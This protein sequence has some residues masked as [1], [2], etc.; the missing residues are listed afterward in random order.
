MRSTAT[1]S[2]VLALGPLGALA[3]A[4]PAA[5]AVSCAGERATVVGTPASDRLFGTAGRDVIAGLG[6]GDVI[7]G[8]G[9]H[10]LVCGGAGRDDLRG[11]S[12]P[13]LVRGGDGS[14]RLRGGRGADTVSSGAAGRR[15]GSDLFVADP[16]DDRILGRRAGAGSMLTFLHAEHRVVVDLAAG[17]SWSR[18]LG[19]D[20]V[21]GVNQ[22]MGSRHDDSLSGSRRADF[23]AGGIG[24][25][26]IDGRGGR[27]FLD[28]G[29]GADSVRGAPGSDIALLRGADAA[30][31]GAGSDLFAVFGDAVVQAGTGADFA[32][33]LRGDAD[34]RGGDG[35]DLV[36][37]G[38]EGD[39]PVTIDLRAGT[40]E[41]GNSSARLWSF[42]DA[43]GGPGPDTLSGTAGRNSLHGDRGAD[44][45]R[46]LAG[47]DSL[48]GGPGVDLLDGGAGEDRCLDDRDTR[49]DCETIPSRTGASSYWRLQGAGP[50]SLVPADLLARWR[51]TPR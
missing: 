48:D 41:H 45:L 4:P 1:L 34:V 36:A 23:F 6:G 42:E 17:S 24:M 31:L 47:R 29:V 35:R 43:A 28:S 13:D 27:D 7:R 22:V 37:M 44:T 16:G 21:S 39:S 49:V 33:F 12:G 11:G 50:G 32:L 26:A 30:R 8:R 38:F 9:G 3:V 25:D 20:R 19:T 2:A 10:D 14:D 18:G 46:G 5:A 51:A 40:G 15:S